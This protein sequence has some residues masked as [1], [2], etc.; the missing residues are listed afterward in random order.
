MRARLAAALLVA[1]AA[2]SANAATT[3]KSPKALALQ[4]SDFPAGATLNNPAQ[5]SGPGGS[6]Y[7][8]TFDVKNGGQEEEVTNYVSVEPNTG[9]ANSTYAI[10]KATIGSEPGEQALSLP[11]YGDTQAA[12]W[13]VV[14]RGGGAKRARSTLT[15]RKGRI[16]WYLIVENCGVLAP[17]ACF[18]P[19]MPPQITEAKAVAEL[20]KYALKQKSRIGSSG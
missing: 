9:S 1:C 15:V 6:F 8:Q 20:K 10:Q 2:A 12:N 18:H 19:P 11:S 13:A 14:K 7:S 17:D 5:F 3:A 4:L 16:V